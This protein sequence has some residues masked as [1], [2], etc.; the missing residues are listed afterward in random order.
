[1]NY[2]RRYVAD[3]GSKTGALSMIEDGAYNRLLD[4]YYEHEQPLP[5]APARLY[6]IARAIAPAERKAVDHVLTTYFDKREDGWHNGRADAELAEALPK[7]G[8]LRRV[9]RENGA[10][11][12]RPSKKKTE[13]GSS[14]QPNPVSEPEPDRQPDPEPSSQP[15]NPSTP[16]TT[17]FP[18]V[19][20]SGPESP[21]AKSA[22]ET[23]LEVE[24]RRPGMLNLLRKHR[25][26]GV[27]EHPLIVDRILATAKDGDIVTA[28]HEASRAKGGAAFD[29]GFLDS[30]VGRIA[31]AARES[32]ERIRSTSDARVERTRQQ[33]EEQRAWETAQMPE[34]V[35][36]QIPRKAVA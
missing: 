21:S 36:A 7:L 24:R 35:R 6:Q 8:N 13:S 23:N 28:F 4:W 2:Y 32:E 9:A 12:G 3:Y 17:A 14:A 34:H 31:K 27:D 18:V 19:T 16:L 29:I 22:G 11:G 1:M 30:I 15:L 33:T 25:V 10:K 5:S 26:L 20:T